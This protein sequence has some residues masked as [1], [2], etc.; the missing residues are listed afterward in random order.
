MSHGDHLVEA[1][2]EEQIARSYDERAG[3]TYLVSGGSGD[4]T[5]Y[6]ETAEEQAERHRAHA[7]AHLAAADTLAEDE[8]AAC[9]GAPEEART[10][11]PLMGPAELVGV[12]EI[13]DGVRIVLDTPDVALVQRSV[14]CHVGHAAFLH[15]EGMD[16]CVFYLQEIQV[17]VRETKDART[18]LFITSDD[19]GVVEE[20]RN[21]TT[22][23]WR[24]STRLDDEIT[25]R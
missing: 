19:S 21:R 22:R 9:S 12:S 20:I 6:I 3:E 11:C 15:Y 2:Q 5:F 13:P 18:E 16:T 25:H 4:Y 24:S 17:D 10:S 8:A 1:K 7:N 14:G 23:A